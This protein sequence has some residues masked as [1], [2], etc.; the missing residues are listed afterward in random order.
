MPGDPVVNI[1]GN[2]TI[3]LLPSSDTVINYTICQGQSYMGYSTTT[4]WSDTLTSAGGCDSIIHYNLTVNPLP[5]VTASGTNAICIGQQQ[6][7]LSGS[8]AAS[9]TWSA[10]VINGIP[11]TLGCYYNIHSNRYRCQWLCSTTTKLVTVNALPS[12][13]ALASPND[14]LC[15]GNNITLSGNGAFTYTRVEA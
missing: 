7:T 5:N 6:V 11:F 4:S 2:A 12:V 15:I 8:G 9:Y 3:N 14:T 1:I 13:S 10:G